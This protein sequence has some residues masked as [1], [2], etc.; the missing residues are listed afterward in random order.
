MQPLKSEA[1][2]R[3]LHN[4]THADLAALYSKGME[5]QVNVARGQGKLVKQ[6]DFK[7]KEW[8]AWTDGE[9]TWK[10]FRIPLKA[11]SEPEDNDGPVTYSMD[12]HAEGIGMTGW[13]WQRKQSLWVAFDFDAILGHSD[14][15]GKKLDDAELARVAE[16]VKDIPFVTLR[17]STSGKGLHLYVFLEPVATLN[18][19]EHAA[20]AR[21][22]L[23]MMSGLSG[24]DFASKVDVCGGNMWV[25]HRKMYNADGVQNDG[26]KLIK[27]G[28]KLTTIPANWKEH[29]NVI[30]RKTK[31]SVP[32]FVDRLDSNDP[33]DLFAELTGQRSRVALEPAHRALIDYL[34]NNGCVWW[35]DSDSHMLVT[36][37]VHLKAAH[38]DM[39]MCGR[40][41]TIATGK[42]VGADHNCFA[43][44]LRGG[45]WV[46]RKYT[47]RSTETETWEQDTA[48]WTRCFYNREPDI[49]TLARLNEGIELKKGGYKF[50]HASQVQKIL[51]ELGV[52]I[53]LPNFVMSREAILKLLYRENKVVVSITAEGSDDGSKMKG[54]L[55]EK[56][57]WERVFRCDLH[58]NSD[59]EGQENYDDLLRHIVSL[60]YQDAG[61]VMN[62]E[63]TWIGEPLVH[64]KAA[65][66]S[67]GRDTK[68]ITQI[69][70]AGVVRSW[71]LVNKPFQPEYPGNRE[72]NRNAAQ[73]AIAPTTDTDVL[74]YPTWTRILEHCG[75]GLN[76]A[77]AEH[78]W[79]KANA[80]TRGSE[81][82]MLWIASMFK[83]PDAPTSYLAFW[84]PQD[85]GKSIFH[86]MISQI[87]VTKGVMRADNALQSQSN[88]NGELENA[89]LCVVEETDLR[90]DKTAY[91]RIKDWVTSP[92]IMIR[93]LYTTGYMSKNTTH[94]IQCMNE[95][96]NCP[97]FPGDT[98]ITLT[99]VPSLAPGEMIAK[100]ELLAMLRKEAPDF[101]A[102]VLAM[103]LPKSHD[104]L[105]VP[106]ISTEGKLRA[107]AKNQSL[108]E[109]FL[110]E[111]IHDVMG[112]C[113][114][115]DEFYEKF[116]LWLD[117]RDRSY[118][119]RQRTGRELP[120][121]YPRGRLSNDQRVHFGNMSWDSNAVPGTPYVAQKAA[122]VTFIRQV[123]T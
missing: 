18:H 7:G 50:R 27:S 103:E 100:D 17:K 41:E 64:V 97:I 1:I 3:F 104:R 116:V 111:E 35:W 28:A 46:V 4:K 93:P 114:P 82:L 69:I 112:H 66:S 13:N 94:W 57:V 45:A 81:Y 105:A 67:H 58:A 86:E 60:D 37:T 102:A 88:F 71:Q 55:N 49:H 34:S 107:A 6:G 70:G 23:S 19:T 48:G 9:F 51:I 118:W 5:V 106:T 99:H 30:S 108:L 12:M 122:T 89:I 119:T 29:V 65:L 47:L 33:D 8:N 73:F 79:C 117:E 53:D 20:L 101:L 63:K 61:W 113:I 83:R 32:T 59:G 91:N 84:G 68:E 44:P 10:P 36:H 43:F 75:N 16:V 25:W 80:I 31:R 95:M 87:L 42:D 72:W 110:E 74:S 21:S 62:K 123:A 78:E 121:R 24:F 98:R 85:S 38:N 92:E 76:E 56:K 52:N 109:L 90:K 11:N 54:W 96:E 39:R 14:K 115:G 22:I 26:L 40:F 15:H 2:S 120:E 77:I